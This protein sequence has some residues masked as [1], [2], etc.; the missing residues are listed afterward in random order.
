VR[1]S[2]QKISL[3]QLVIDKTLICDSRHGKSF[4]ADAKSSHEQPRGAAF[5][6]ARQGVYAMSRIFGSAVLAVGIVCAPVLFA[7]RPDNGAGQRHMRVLPSQRVDAKP[8]SAACVPESA[9]YNPAKC[10]SRS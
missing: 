8:M 4:L 5:L 9:F 6:S 7:D 2:L 10:G 3:L 1:N